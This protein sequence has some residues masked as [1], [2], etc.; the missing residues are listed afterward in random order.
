MSDIVER[1]MSAPT[2]EL[3]GYAAVRLGQLLGEA[4]EEIERLHKGHCK[5]C[6][7]TRS[8]A[9]LGITESTG[10]SIPEEIERL[11]AEL[12]RLAEAGTGYSQQTVD[13]ITKEREA[14][15]GEYEKL[16]GFYRRDGM[17][18]LLTEHWPDVAAVLRAAAMKEHSA[19]GDESD[20]DERDDNPYC[21]CGSSPGEEE[22]AAN[23]CSCCGKRLEP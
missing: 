9:A 22:D 17:E 18:A 6:C 21:D 23:R 19:M 11:R 5:D 7:C 12:S 20:D 8:W 14:L 3:H 15:R 10:R 4:A 2:V 1:L 13:A 16:C